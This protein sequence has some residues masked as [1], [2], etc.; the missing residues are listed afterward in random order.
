[1]TQDAEYTIEDATDDA[2]AIAE[3]EIE[4]SD[5]PNAIG[6]HAEALEV[7]QEEVRPSTAVALEL[8]PTGHELLSFAHQ[9]ERLI[10]RCEKSTEP[11][12][13]AWGPV[14]QSLKGAVSNLRG[15]IGHTL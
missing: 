9:L 3:A 13:G 12:M 11:G 1:M 4:E 5:I 8:P 6:D 14:T 7:E 15:A 2:N 10:G